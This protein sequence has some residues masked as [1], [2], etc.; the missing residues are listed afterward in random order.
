MRALT[1]FALLIA[2]ILAQFWML[3]PLEDA[4]LYTYIVVGRWLPTRASLTEAELQTPAYLA[5]LASWIFAQVDSWAGLRG[6]HTLHILLMIASFTCLCMWQALVMS[7]STGAAPSPLVLG[8][9]MVGAYLVSATNSDARTQDF[10]YLSF[11]LLLLLMERWSA[12]ADT[13]RTKVLHA[14]TIL[15]LLVFWQNAHATVLLSLPIIATYVVWRQLPWAYL[16]LPPLASLCTANGYN[17]YSWTAT[18]VEISRDLLNISEWR[19]PWDLTVLNPMLPFWFFTLLIVLAACTPQTRRILREPTTA[20]LSLLFF[21]LTLTS[22]RFGALWGFVSAPLFGAICAAL[23]PGSLAKTPIKSTN[24]TRY[25]I[26]TGISLALLAANPGRALPKDSPLPIFRSLKAQYPTARIFNYREYGGILEYLGYPGWSVYI[27]GRILLFS[28][29]TWRR[30]E[31]IANAHDR[32]LVDD[33]VKTHDLLV[34][35]PSYHRSLIEVLRTHDGV[36]L[37]SEDHAVVIFAR[38]RD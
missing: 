13:R 38:R 18:N 3:R 36:Q 23:W 20:T 22:A 37:L 6:V 24:V 7:R 26:L 12:Q 4:D 21:V 15:A 30:Y 16:F 9:G 28:P 10:T 19:H 2:T 1:P 5:W 17:I 32:S 11:S 8:F 14:I 27:D 25:W 34:L 35:H 29:D 33:V 31:A